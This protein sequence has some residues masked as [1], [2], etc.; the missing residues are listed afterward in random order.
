VG[1]QLSGWVATVNLP[2]ARPTTDDVLTA[3]A[4]VAAQLPA[5]A[6]QL[7][8]GLLPAGEQV[9]FADFLITVGLITRFHALAI[10]KNLLIPPRDKDTAMA[11][12]PQKAEDDHVKQV[13]EKT[14]AK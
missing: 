2:I 12:D 9:E 1:R 6:K 3:L 7:D 5:A 8:Q 13:K 11:D 4:Q 14:G 10:T